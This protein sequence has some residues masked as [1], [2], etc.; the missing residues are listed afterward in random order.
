[1]YGNI[2]VIHNVLKEKITLLNSQ[3]VQYLK[4]FIILKKKKEDN[5]GKKMKKKCKTQKIIGKKQKK[6]GGKTK[7]EI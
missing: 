1:M 6:Y 2:V 4:K 3:S 7:K 5:L